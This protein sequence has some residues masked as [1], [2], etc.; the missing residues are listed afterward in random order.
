MPAE[1]QPL[2]LLDCMA[3]VTDPRIDR[4]KDHL[5]IDILF[6]AICSLICGGDDFTDMEEFGNAKE[7]GLQVGIS[8]LCVCFSKPDLRRY[9]SCSFVF[10]NPN[11]KYLTFCR[12]FINSND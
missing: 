7:V 12:R 9:G 6:F 1:P 4:C 10:P 5:L 3:E 2:A 8:S 11:E